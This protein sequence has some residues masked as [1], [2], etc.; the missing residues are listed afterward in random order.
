M[1]KP[2][3]VHLDQTVKTNTRPTV[4]KRGVGG[5]LRLWTEEIEERFGGWRCEVS[6][7]R[8]RNG[9]KDIVSRRMARPTARKHQRLATA[10]ARGRSK[11]WGFKE[12]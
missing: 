1:V 2:F 8:E 9:E 11:M 5:W 3:Y 4:R 6:F 7:I 12:I 10:A